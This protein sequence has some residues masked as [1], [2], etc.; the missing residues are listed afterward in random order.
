MKKF[1]A[2]VLL[3]TFLMTGCSLLIA[4]E[5]V[6]TVDSKTVMKKIKNKETFV[7]VIGEEYCGACKQYFE[8]LKALKKE[9]GVVF[10]YIDIN[11]ENMDDF[12]ELIFDYIETDDLEYTP[13]TIFVTDG[14]AGELIVG[15]ISKEEIVEFYL[16][17]TK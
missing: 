7:L 5:P 8:S 1:V 6:N 10:D 12:L 14:E 15:S 9:K 4:E 17:N 16:E 3:L 13:T 2:F 11:K